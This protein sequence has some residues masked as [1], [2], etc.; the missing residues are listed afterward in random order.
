VTN[1][2]LSPKLVII[3]RFSCSVL[4]LYKLDTS[5]ISIVKDPK[6]SDT[7]TCQT[8]ICVRHRYV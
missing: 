3:Q 2:F 6:L 8:R 5:L 7:D 1:Y 4:R